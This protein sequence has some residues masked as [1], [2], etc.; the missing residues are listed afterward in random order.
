MPI[1][2][3]TSIGGY[4]NYLDKEHEIKVHYQKKHSI[5]HAHAV[6]VPTGFEY[7]HANKCQRGNEC[8]IWKQAC[9]ISI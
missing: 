3:F 2:L 8:P 7:S 5:G 6:L 1:A 9:K 4:C